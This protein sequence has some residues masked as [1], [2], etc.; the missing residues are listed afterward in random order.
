MLLLLPRSFVK[1]VGFQRHCKELKQRS[2]FRFGRVG[3]ADLPERGSSTSLRKLKGLGAITSKSNNTS[4]LKSAQGKNASK[5]LHF[6]IEFYF[7]SNSGNP[8]LKI[9]FGYKRAAT[10]AA[11]HK[12]LSFDECC[13]F[14]RNHSSRKH[15]L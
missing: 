9:A 11:L 13:Q 2:Y 6:C 1:N 3:A 10:V 14:C 5:E 8:Y 7:V 4:L 15:N 12:G